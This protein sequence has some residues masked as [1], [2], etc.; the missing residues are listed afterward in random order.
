MCDGSADPP[1]TVFYKLGFCVHMTESRS[2]Q[3]RV[4]QILLKVG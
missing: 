2:Q 1:I 4:K 3:K